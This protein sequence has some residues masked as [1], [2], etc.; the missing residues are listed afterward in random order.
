MKHYL[1]TGQCLVKLILLNRLW[2]LDGR[3]I[4]AG[5][6][7]LRQPFQIL[8]I[9]FDKRN[10]ALWNTMGFELSTRCVP[11]P[12]QDVQRLED[13]RRFRHG[14]CQKSLVICLRTLICQRLCMWLRGLG[15][16]L[17]WCLRVSQLRNYAATVRLVE[18]TQSLLV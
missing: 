18:V 7:V 14:A 11:E 2:S 1:N 5:P 8:S 6:R 17:T 12:G 3:R 15:K 13:D 16:C 10:D 9:L 4:G